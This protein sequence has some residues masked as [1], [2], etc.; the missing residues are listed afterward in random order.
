LVVAS[1]GARLYTYF[2][3][4]GCCFLRL[5]L[6]GTVGCCFG[7]VLSLLYGWL[8]LPLL[9]YGWLLLLRY[10]WLSIHGWFLGFFAPFLG[11]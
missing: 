4:V 6:Y 3:T 8:L 11:C 5:L 9:L 7:Y 10:G 2:R 1:V